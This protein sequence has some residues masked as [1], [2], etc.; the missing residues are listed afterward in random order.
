MLVRSQCTIN[1]SILFTEVPILERPAAAA[2]AGFSAVEFWWP[3]SRARPGDHEVD[4]FL[5]AVLDSGVSL[6]GLNLFAGDMAAGDRGILSHPHRQREYDENVAVVRT[7]A[8][9]TGCRIFNALYGTRLPDVTPEEQDE[10][11]L[12]RLVSLASFTAETGATVVLEPLSAVATYPLLTAADVMAILNRLGESGASTR[13]A[14]LADLYHLAVNGDDISAA[15]ATYGPRIGHVQI[16]DAP[17]RNEPGTGGLPIAR[18]T[19]ELAHVGYS[20]LIGLEYKP[21]GASADSF[22]WLE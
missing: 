12:E 17:G 6:T 7:I 4:A 18:W 1:C 5:G 21:S 16:A 11:A 9:A 3:F 8:A 22:A 14:L 19:Q 13:V 2:S 15:I 20:G 10:T